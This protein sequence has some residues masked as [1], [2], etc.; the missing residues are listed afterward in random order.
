MICYI[1]SRCGVN[2]THHYDRGRWL[3]QTPKRPLHGCRRAW[4]R[5][6]PQWRFAVGFQMLQWNSTE[7]PGRWTLPACGPHIYPAYDQRQH[8]HCLSVVQ[9]SQP[10]AIQTAACTWNALPYHVTS[11]PSLPAYYSRLKTHLFRVF[12]PSTFVVHVKW[13]S[14]YQTL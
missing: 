13:R 8:H 6:Y 3:H 7:V 4:T 5:S 10:L 2:V 1:I 14:H 9:G 12:I 11:A